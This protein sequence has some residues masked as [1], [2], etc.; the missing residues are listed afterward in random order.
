MKI[1]SIL[2]KWGKNEYYTN[3]NNNDS[4]LAMI[5]DKNPSVPLIE[6]S[7]FKEKYLMEDNK[8]EEIAESFCFSKISYLGFSFLISSL[9]LIFLLY[10]LTSLIY[11]G[12]QTNHAKEADEFGYSLFLLA[13]FLSLIAIILYF[14]G[15]VKRKHLIL[16]PNIILHLS[17][18]IITFFVAIYFMILIFGG[19]SINI[20]VLIR[21]V[22]HDAGST[23]T[24][25]QN[26]SDNIVVGRRLG[27]FIPLM[28]I[29]F[30]S[31]VTIFVIECLYLFVIK[32]CFEIIRINN[33]KTFVNSKEVPGSE[34]C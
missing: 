17:I 5:D 8:K 27:N 15:L 13:N 1:T 24:I 33:L 10:T 28:Y 18:I 30:F 25:M 7:S 22:D 12:L 6:N 2:S 21:T 29:G 34:M 26:K 11:Y 20:N 19:I 23:G 31:M 14:I 16:I 3:E 32:K 4:I 9:Q